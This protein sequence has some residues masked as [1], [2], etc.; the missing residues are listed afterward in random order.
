[1]LWRPTL[2]MTDREKWDVVIKN[3]LK[4]VLFPSGVCHRTD[5]GVTLMTTAPRC[6]P[7]SLAAAR[8]VW[9][10]PAILLSAE[11]GC[12]FCLCSAARR[13]CSVWSHTCAR[14]RKWCHG[15]QCN[16]PVWEDKKPSV[17]VRT[18]LLHL[19]SLRAEIVFSMVSVSLVVNCE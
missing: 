13:A 11:A 12:S 17:A 19:V 1:M 8:N 2:D 4:I 3:T 14:S 6:F 9:H 5:S 15:S 18:A 7:R 16:L 10:F